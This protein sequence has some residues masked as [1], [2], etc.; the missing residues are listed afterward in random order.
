MSVTDIFSEVRYRDSSVLPADYLL[1]A[2]FNINS[3]Q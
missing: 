1:L 3:V 2:Y